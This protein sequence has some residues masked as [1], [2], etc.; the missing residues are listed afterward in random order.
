MQKDGP[1]T[2]KKHS[3]VEVVKQDAQEALPAAT[4][5]IVELERI[6]AD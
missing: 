4:Y 5:R 3:Q 6:I 1:A 2:W